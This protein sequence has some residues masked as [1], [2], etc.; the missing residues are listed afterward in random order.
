MFQTLTWYT[1]LMKIL[2]EHGAE[3]DAKDGYGRSPIDIAEEKDLHQRVALL[4]EWKR[5]RCV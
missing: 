2:L 5:E 1:D 3:V 4:Q